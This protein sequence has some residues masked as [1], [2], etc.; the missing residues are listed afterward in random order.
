MSWGF[1]NDP[2][3]QEELDW[4][5]EFV[6]TEVEPVDQVIEHA[7][8]PRDPLRNALIKPLQQKVRERKLW[9]AHLGLELCGSGYAQ[10]RLAL[11]N[12][13]LGRTHAGPVVFG[14]R[15]LDPGRSA[16]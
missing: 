7:W 12:E 6:R 9:A 14:C 2:E 3:V 15:S 10:L 1:E 5:E 13:K 8:N 16:S 4:V 11:L